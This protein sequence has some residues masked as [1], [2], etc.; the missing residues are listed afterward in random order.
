MIHTI[1]WMVAREAE[2]VRS[3]ISFVT[4]GWF[5]LGGLVGGTF[6][7]VLVATLARVLFLLLDAGTRPFAAFAAIVS[8]MAL[9]QR[10][11]LWTIPF[12]QFRHQVPEAWRNTFSTRVGAFVYAGALGFAFFTKVT[13]LVFYPL[14]VLGLGLGAAPFAIVAIFAIQGLARASTGIFVLLR[15]DWLT[16]EGDLVVSELN[17]WIGSVRL[18]EIAVLGFAT[19][20]SV[21]FAAA[22]V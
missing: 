1:R 8:L 19:A 13:S 15:P 12:P 10:L 17:R 7:G 14:V 18:A 22:R 21:F 2:P 3:R 6:A 16:M 4:L 20:W 5:L 9:G 11:R